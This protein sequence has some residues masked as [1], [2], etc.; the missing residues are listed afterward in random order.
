MALKACREC[1]KQVSTEAAKCPHCGTPHPTSQF[2]KGARGCLWFLGI[3]FVISMMSTLLPEADDDPATSQQAA[4]PKAAVNPAITTFL[5]T[6][7]EFGQVQFVEPMPNW[8]KG[9][10]QR[11]TTSAG[12]FLFYLQTGDVVTV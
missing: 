12:S 9:E 3:V 4:A 8:A 5:A 7:P 11:V 1:G 10:R 2:S 6:H